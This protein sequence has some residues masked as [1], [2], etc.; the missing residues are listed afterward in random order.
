MTALVFVDTNV[1]AYAREPSDPAKRARAREWLDVLWRELRGR[2]SLQVLNEYYSLLTRRAKYCVSREVAWDDICELLEWR[3]QEID[4]EVLKRAYEI[5]GRY[6]LNWWDS[7][8]VAAA[9]AQACAILLTED[10]QDRAI[11]GGVTVR[12]HS[13][14]ASKKRTSRTQHSPSLHRA[15][16]AADGRAAIRRARPASSWI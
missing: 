11:Y 13:H 4:A 16:A 9:Q 12:T 2:T 15:T 14:W 10:L 6:R 3:P 1:F 7:L 8:I 5:E